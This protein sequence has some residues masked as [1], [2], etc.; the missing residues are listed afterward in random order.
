MRVATLSVV[1]IG[2]VIVA[3]FVDRPTEELA[4]TSNSQ[5]TR[6]DPLRVCAGGYCV[7]P[8]CPDDC[9]ACDEAAKTCQVD[10]TSTDDCLGQ[11]TCPTGWDCTI[12]CVGDGACN[13]IEC[14]TG[15]KCTIA[16]TGD[17]ACSD[18]RC[19]SAC[20]CDL[21]CVGTACE[22]MACPVIGNGANQVRCTADG[23]TATECDSTV[24]SRCARC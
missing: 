6:F 23:T 22:A 18:I 15:A 8:D 24:D 5:C 20:Q 10:C 2:S 13:D 9:T 3:C 4:C 14:Q 11:I 7:E 21:D 17:N 12:N 1:L 16:C 19:S